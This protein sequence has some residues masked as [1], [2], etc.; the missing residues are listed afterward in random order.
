MAI[1]H[2]E[3]KVV[4]RGTGRSVCAA[5]AYISCSKIYNEYDGIQHNYTRKRG[6]VWAH[7]FLPHNAPPE[8]A[9]RG[10]LWNA[11]E[12]EETA[13]DSRLA[14]EIIVALPVELSVEEWKKLLTD[15]IREQFVKEGM[16]VDVVIHDPDPAGHNPHAHILVT[17]RPLDEQGQWQYKTEKEYLCIRNEEERGF[18]GA[19]F[20]AAQAKGWE[21]QYLY[22]SEEGKKVWLTPSKA[23]E[24][25][26]V[27]VNKHPK[28]TKYGRQNPITARWNSEEQ[29]VLWRAAWADVTNRY[30][31]KAGREERIDHRSNAARGLEEQPTIHEGVAAREMEKRGIVSERC[32]LNRQIRAENALLRKLKETVAALPQKVQQT[33]PEIAVRLEA[34]RD[35]LIVIHYKYSY[36]TTLLESMRKFMKNDIPRIEKLQTVRTDIR[37]K[38]KEKKR[39]TAE[40]ENTP[41]GSIVKRVQLTT[42]ITTLTEEIE[43]LKFQKSQIMAE[44]YCE[45]ESEA[46][47]LEAEAASCPNNKALAEE[48]QKTLT[49]QRQTAE[50]EY[51][52]T[53]QSIAPENLQAVETECQSIRSHGGR[54]ALIQKLRDIYGEL[55]DRRQYDASEEAVDAALSGRKTSHERTPIAEQL[56]KAKQALEQKEPVRQQQKKKRDEVEH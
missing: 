9:D 33:I 50:K 45:D 20:K 11:V 42:Q 27:R 3:V 49:A 51:V 29:L 4:S 35:S 48:Q 5:S 1:Y 23:K 15:F 47:K 21:K 16:C 28:D 8:W 25:G 7:V 22:M 24:R 31:E 19:E 46:K 34:L 41:L 54:T 39:L 37:Q 53:L 2:V 32:E 26:L 55:F 30:L 6:L 44:L 14:R 43:E 36:N 38:T 52:E 56:E 40:K 18:T 17:V 10:R 13:K 12:A